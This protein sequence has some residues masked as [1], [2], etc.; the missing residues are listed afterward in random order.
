M[1][2]SYS[3]QPGILAGKQ[4]IRGIGKIRVGSKLVS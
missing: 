2:F 4:G 3:F 1:V